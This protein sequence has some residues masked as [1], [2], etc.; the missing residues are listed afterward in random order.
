MKHLSRLTPAE[1]L[2]LQQ[3]EK[4]PFNEVLKYT[5]MDL[6][7][8]QALVIEQVPREP[9][10]FDASQVYK[11]IMRG[12]NFSQYLQYQ[13]KFHER[14]FLSTF[15]DQSDIRIL[16]RNL[17]KVGYQKAESARMLYPTIAL[18][19]DL[20]KP[21]YRT[22]YQWLFG[23]FKYTQAGLQWQKEVQNE[24]RELENVI[25]DLR[26]D[27]ERNTEILRAVGGNIFLLKGVDFALA[28]EIDRELFEEMARRNNPD[29]SVGGCWTCFDDY[30]HTFDSSCSSDTWTSGDG[31]SGCSGDSGCSGCGGCGGD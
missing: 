26:K 10:S 18:R 13:S 9:T 7:L 22:F 1:T 15:R 25:S 21:F 3:G 28:T 6:L 4:A 2:I 29:G 30:S 27:K 17:V 31:N 11:Y 20:E 16:F 23:G 12:K 19:M 8:K 14:I 24:M 5:L